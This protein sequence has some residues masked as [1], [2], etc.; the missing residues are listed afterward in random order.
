MNRHALGRVVGWV[1]LV[2]GIV[3]APVAVV[4]PLLPAT[5]APVAVGARERPASAASRYPADSL[6]ARIAAH[7]LFRFDRRPATMPY[8]PQRP[9]AVLGTYTPPKPALRLVGLVSA[10]EPAALIEGLPGI[11]GGRVLRR[12][13]RIAGLT[14]AAIERGRVR[15]VGMDTVWVLTLRRP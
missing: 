13:D 15:V 3:A 7:D 10:A 14:I 8:D 2:S 1:V 11:E 12:G 4:R 5:S 9:A 6:A